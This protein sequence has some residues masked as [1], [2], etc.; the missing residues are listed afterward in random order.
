MPHN[1]SSEVLSLRSFSFSD[2]SRL[3]LRH[4]EGPPAAAERSADAGS[5]ASRHRPARAHRVRRKYARPSFEP[6]STSLRRR[7]RASRVL[8]FS[9]VTV[10]GSLRL[11]RVRAR[12]ELP[13]EPFACW[14]LYC[15]I[16][17]RIHTVL[18]CRV[19]SEININIRIMR[20]WFLLRT[21]LTSVSC[22]VS[23]ST[24][25][26]LYHS[27]CTSTGLWDEYTLQYI[28]MQ[29]R[30]KYMLE[31]WS[32][33]DRIS[34]LNIA[35]HQ[36]SI[37]TPTPPLFS[38]MRLLCCASCRPAR[39]A[40][41]DEFGHR[42]GHRRDVRADSAGLHSNQPGRF[43]RLLRS[44]IASRRLFARRRVFCSPDASDRLISTV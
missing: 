28:W 17:I 44:L 13:Y 10:D 15:Y 24:V 31:I 7:G 30:V 14:F 23:T 34:T 22:Y 11:C 4:E 6:R 38:Y 9:R 42:R 29:Y 18:V 2:L 35:Y 16:R 25:L 26:V 43:A 37:D 36:L 39:R 8:A 5:Q 20:S 40:V 19:L 27:D 3:P 41:R 32:H 21:H 33:N 1:S 12:L